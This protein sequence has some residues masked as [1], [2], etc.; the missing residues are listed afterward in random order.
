[1]KHSELESWSVT[2]SIKFLLIAH[3]S[4]GPPLVLLMGARS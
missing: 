3:G 1:M 4:G 2:T